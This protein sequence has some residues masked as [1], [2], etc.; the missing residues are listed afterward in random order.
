MKIYLWH[1]NHLRHQHCKWSAPSKSSSEFPSARPIH[2]RG[3]G[4]LIHSGDSERRPSQSVQ[5]VGRR[6]HERAED[7]ALNSSATCSR[8]SDRGGECQKEKCE[9]DHQGGRREDKKQ[10]YLCLRSSLSI[11]ARDWVNMIS[12]SDLSTQ[13]NSPKADN[14]GQGRI[15]QAMT[16]AQSCATIDKLA[17]VWL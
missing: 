5:S 12:C 15:K 13:P 16:L 1:Q 8:Q 6:A 3:E 4:F 7:R 10:L 17:K 9:E 11:V 2:S 14:H